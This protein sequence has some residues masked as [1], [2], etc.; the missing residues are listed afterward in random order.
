[1]TSSLLALGCETASRPGDTEGVQQAAKW[2]WYGRLVLET[3]STLALTRLRIDSGLPARHDVILARYDF[4]PTTL[5]AGDE[6]ALT[7]GLDLG[8]ARELPLGNPLPLGPPPGRIPAFGLV[9]C[10]CRPLRPD[11]VRGTLR[12]L[13]R[14]VRQ[15]TARLDATLY[16]TA[17]HDTTMHAAYPLRQTLYGVK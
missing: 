5:S 3:D 14:G 12:I 11:S 8:R 10:L 4:D 2:E 13:Q 16:F 1:L 6:Y 9:T 15:I 7:I 17:W